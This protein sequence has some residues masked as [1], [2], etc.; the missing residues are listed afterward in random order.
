MNR[1]VTALGAVAL[2]LP[3]LGLP[4]AVSAS[5]LPDPGRSGS[6]TVERQDTAGDPVTDPVDVTV[7]LIRYD[8]AG[9]AIDLTT[10]LGWQRAAHVTVYDAPL[11]ADPADCLTQ[12]GVAGI[13]TF[14]NLPLG[15]W[16]VS[17]TYPGGEE[18]SEPFL[19]PL[20]R[21]DEDGQTWIYDVH[22]F[23][24]PFDPDP[25]PNRAAIG[26]TV[27][28]DYNL[29]GVID[30]GESRVPNVTVSVYRLGPAPL[31]APTALVAP[32]TYLGSTL[33]A[34]DGTWFM[35][36]LPAGQKVVRFNVSTAN[37]LE[38]FYTFTNVGPDFQGADPA[39]GLTDAVTV[40]YDEI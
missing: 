25:V 29:D 21:I 19:T 34:A 38:H 17:L 20:P 13:A 35:G 40:V 22:A 37:S 36:N 24:K 39:T 27:W 2:T 4:S 15:L 1:L 8:A 28:R 31:T 18:A 7:C 32:G 6:L 14:S 5:S 11:L 12:L 3:L 10:N 9:N 30:A 16:H 23:P 33:T 26:G